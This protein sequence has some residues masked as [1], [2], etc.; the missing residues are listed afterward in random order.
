MI[1]QYGATRDAGAPSAHLRIPQIE[2]IGEVWREKVKE[3]MNLLSLIRVSNEG[4]PG[5]GA[6]CCPHRHTATRLL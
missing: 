3:G 5:G 4:N 2:G 6:L 1:I